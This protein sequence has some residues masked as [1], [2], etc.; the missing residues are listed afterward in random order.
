VRKIDTCRFTGDVTFELSDG[1]YLK[2]TREQIHTFGIDGIARRYGQEMPN[3]DA[4]TIVIQDGREIGTLPA[5]FDPD[6]IK[7]SNWLYDPRP[8]DF[9]RQGDTW[10]AAPTLGPGDLQAVPGFRRKEREA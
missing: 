9:R 4:R 10:V 3:S 7:S 5:S 2:V 6:F 8:G 1:S